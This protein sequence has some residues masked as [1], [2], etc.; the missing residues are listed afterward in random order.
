MTTMLQKL[1]LAALGTATLVLGQAVAASAVTFTL[2]GTTGDAN[3]HYFPEYQNAKFEGYFIVPDDAPD[4]DPSDEAGLFEISD[5]LITLVNECFPEF[6]AVFKKGSHPAYFYQ[7]DTDITFPGFDIFNDSQDN[8]TFG[9]LFLSFSGKVTSPNVLPT[10]GPV[11]GTFNPHPS[12]L[13]VGGSES[14]PDLDI[15]VTSA[16]VQAVPEPTTIA[17]A[18]IFGLGVLLKKRRKQ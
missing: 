14:A 7:D 10:F 3:S 11:E 13:S 15:R 1:S 16:S 18:T 12:F 2:S 9:S 17:G 6:K 5:Y 8:P 4:L